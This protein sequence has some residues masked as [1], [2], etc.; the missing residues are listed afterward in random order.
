MKYYVLTRE[1]KFD[2]MLDAQK[3]GRYAIHLSRVSKAE[4]GGPNK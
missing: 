4:S 3:C 1:N 2:Y